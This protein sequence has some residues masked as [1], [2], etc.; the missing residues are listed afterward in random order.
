[1]VIRA[2]VFDIGGV[3]EHTPPTG[4]TQRWEQALGLEPGELDRRM[5]DVWRAGRLGTVSEAEVVAAVGS[6]L[7]LT[8]VQVEDFMAGR[9]EE[10]LGTANTDLIAWFAAL[11]P[12]FRTGILS[13]SFVGARAREE[14]RYGFGA[15]ADVVVYSHEVGIAK[16]DPAVYLLVCERLEVPPEEAVFLDDKAVAVEAAR[17]VGLTGVLF[18]DNAQAI[19]DLEAVLGRT[20]SRPG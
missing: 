20:I 17:A 11:R 15:L 3:L 8:R 16:P 9:W 10:Y 19:A 1:V 2:V 12:Q 5:D 13:N 14:Q 7:R 18:R 4:H 6:R